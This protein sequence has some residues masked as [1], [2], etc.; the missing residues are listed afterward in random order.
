MSCPTVI[1]VT[2][3]T[4]PPGIGLPAGTADAG[5]FVRKAGS[6]AYVY[7]LVT[8]DQVG[9]PQ[10]LAA[11]NSPTFAG[12]TL[13]GMSASVGR[14]LLVGANGQL[15]TVLIGTNLAIVDGAL[16]AAGGSGGGPALSDATPQAL[17]TASAG[18]SAAASRS[19]HRHAMPTAAQVGADPTGTAATE[20][21]AA[22]GNY[23]TAAQGT[24]PR[25]PLYATTT[26]YTASGAIAPIDRV[27]VVNAASAVTMTLGSGSINGQSLTVKRLGAGA[28]TITA[29]LDGASSS[30]VA[31]S[32]TIRESVL[33]AWSSSL[34]TWL[35]L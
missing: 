3:G 11:T 29:S 16:V 22:A 6:T 21:A 7:E 20:V 32:T 10:G 24:D 27:A 28:V 31:D 33:L 15:T 18:T 9:L 35:I 17:G 13:S 14:L 34:S 1:R 8:P 30:I 12:L 23:A 19:D 4:G 2:T 25:P 5:K 26:T